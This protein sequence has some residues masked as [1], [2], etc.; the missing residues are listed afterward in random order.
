MTS[1]LENWTKNWGSEYIQ[2]FENGNGDITMGKIAGAMGFSN[3]ND[4]LTSV[5]NGTFDTVP[6]VASTA[7]DAKSTDTK[8]PATDSEMDKEV[9]QTIDKLNKEDG[10]F[11]SHFDSLMKSAL[12]LASEVQTDSKD[13]GSK[14]QA[15]ENSLDGLTKDMAADQA[16]AKAYATAHKG[17]KAPNQEIVLGQSRQREISSTLNPPSVQI[18]LTTAS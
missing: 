17:D 5:R 8:P 14:A 4:L 6:A 18:Y 15:L 9:Y 11:D 1:G 7:P 3:Q 10:T 16:A 13:Y 2:Q 12:A